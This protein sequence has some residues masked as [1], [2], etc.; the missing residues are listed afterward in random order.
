MGTSTLA[1]EVSERLGRQVL[2]TPKRVALVLANLIADKESKKSDGQ[3][4]VHLLVLLLRVGSPVVG[5]LL[6]L[7]TISVH[8]LLI[9]SCEL[10]APATHEHR[11]VPGMWRGDTS[12]LTRF[13]ND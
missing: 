3:K 9:L 1:F 6:C 7:L 4:G 13:S 12:H 5:S 10:L 11:V 8:T 2:P